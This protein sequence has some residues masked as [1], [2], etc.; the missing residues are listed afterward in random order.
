MALAQAFGGQQG[1]VVETP[2]AVKEAIER[3]I[4][5]VLNSK[6]SYILDMR[7]AQDTPATPTT[8]TKATL[9]YFRQPVLD[10]FH[11]QDLKAFALESVNG[12][13]PVNI[14]SIF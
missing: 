7:M 14:P 10:V 3:A 11:K 9:H 2:G 1:E 13:I 6:T 12:E 5:H 8:P 4:D